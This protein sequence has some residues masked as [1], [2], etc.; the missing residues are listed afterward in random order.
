MHNL[1]LITFLKIKQ[2]PFKMHHNLDL[3][4]YDDNIPGPNLSKV[5]KNI[6]I[7]ESQS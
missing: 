4:V 1:F 2:C 6:E 7:F 3:I 5:G